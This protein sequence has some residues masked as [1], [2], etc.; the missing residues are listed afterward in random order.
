MLKCFN[1]SQKPVELRTVSMSTDEYGQKRLVIVETKTISMQII[2]TQQYN[3]QNPAYIDLSTVGLTRYKDISTDNQIVA[4][5]IVYNIKHMI[6]TGKFL[7]L[8]LAAEN[9]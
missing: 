2:V 3:M 7:R 5:G 4:D 6:D 8:E 9:G 1:R